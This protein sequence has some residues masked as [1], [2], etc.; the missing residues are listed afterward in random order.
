[1]TEMTTETKKKQSDTEIDALF[2]VGAHYGYSR[3]RRHPS[4]VPLLLG[5]KNGVD[6]I[7]LEQTITRLNAA[8]TFAA[9][10]G[11]MGKQVLFVGTK[12]VAANLTKDT[13]QAIGMPYVNNRWI[14]GTLT[15]FSEIKKRVAR[16][17]TLRSKREKGEL[18]QYTKKER[19]MFDREIERL[20]KN[21]GGIVNM[22]DKP[23]ALFVVDFRNEKIAVGEAQEMRV[24]IIGLGSSD[25]DIKNIAYPI[26]ANDAVQKSVAFFVQAIADAY[27]DGVRAKTT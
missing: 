23:A 13:A 5:N 15:N 6:V 11:K 16:L 26:P 25:S 18:S 10:L 17:V 20:E 9:E 21:F 22:S 14:G 3:S 1:M 24:P 8:K 12:S 27:K 2:A 19:L 7:D 4:Y